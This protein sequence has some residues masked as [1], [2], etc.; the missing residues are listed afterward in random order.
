MTD[1]YGMT[2]DLNVLDHP[3]IAYRTNAGKHIVV[4]LKRAGRKMK[5]LESGPK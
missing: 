3:D 4:E 2:V 1:T 5:L